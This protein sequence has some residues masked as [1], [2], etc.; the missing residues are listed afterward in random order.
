MYDVLN[1]LTLNACI[2]PNRTSE[3]ELFYNEH[4]PML[5]QG[6]LCL[7]D[8]AYGSYQLMAENKASES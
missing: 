2:A 6:Y 5:K 4:L 7:L 1:H 8:R 3:Q